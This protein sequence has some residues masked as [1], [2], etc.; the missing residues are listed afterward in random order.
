MNIYQL[1]SIIN[2]LEAEGKPEDS[3]LI[4]FYKDLYLQKLHEITNQVK[5]KLDKE[6]FFNSRPWIEYLTK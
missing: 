5:N 2:R 4:Q 1:K 3:Y 6:A